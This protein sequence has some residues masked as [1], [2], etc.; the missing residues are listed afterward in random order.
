MDVH[1]RHLMI[2]C[3]GM[4]NDPPVSVEGFCAFLARK[5]EAA[6]GEYAVLTSADVQNA[7]YDYEKGER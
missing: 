6:P 4:G 2:N 1:G 3:Y 5:L 7:I